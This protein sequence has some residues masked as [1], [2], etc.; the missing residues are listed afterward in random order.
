MVCRMFGVCVLP[1]TT[2]DV[3]RLPLRLSPKFPVC[4]A[5]FLSPW[6]KAGTERVRSFRLAGAHV[7]CFVPFLLAVTRP[8]ESA[9][10]VFPVCSHAAVVFST[11][12]VLRLRA[13]APLPS[14]HHSRLFAYYTVNAEPGCP[15]VLL[16]FAVLASC[17]CLS[18]SL[19]VFW[20]PLLSCPRPDVQLQ[21]PPLR[22]HRR[23]PSPT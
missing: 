20:L 23:L 13:A 8:C 5:P 16:L 14:P 18:F 7:L 17:S 9:S 22:T 4:F 3:L 21:S 19:T 12:L 15:V 1:S 2:L 6:H 10:L 11:S